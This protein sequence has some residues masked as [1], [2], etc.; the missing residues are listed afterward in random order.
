MS[1]RKDID[2]KALVRRMIDR[3]AE[4][5]H[6]IEA[7]HDDTRPV[8]LDQTTV[9]RLSRMDDMQS[10]AMSIETERRRRDE[11]QR[12]DAALARVDADEY[13]YCLSC[14]D[15]IEKKRIELDPAIPT[16]IGCAK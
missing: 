9:G 15:E 14:G 8:V 10:Q 2:A 6:L 4:L 7:H 13:G 3:K 1:D 11:I 12:I 5:E 16:C